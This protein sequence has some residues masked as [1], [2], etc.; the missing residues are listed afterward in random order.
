M[1]NFSTKT[2]RR[3]EISAELLVLDLWMSVL[4]TKFR[5]V[6]YG[7]NNNNNDSWANTLGAD[8]KSQINMAAALVDDGAAL[9][10]QVIEENPPEDVG[11]REEWAAHVGWHR[12]EDVALRGGQKDHLRPQKQRQR[13][14]HGKQDNRGLNLT[15]LPETIAKGKNQL[16]KT[17]HGVQGNPS[18][19]E[20][21]PLFVLTLSAF[22][23]FGFVA[24]KTLGS[25]A[26]ITSRRKHR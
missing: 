10:Q 22:A 19:S 18:I 14:Q 26:T 8:G 12:R 13:Q 9:V 20:G 6:C 23:C 15:T 4:C 25:R 2:I 3:R 11:V 16:N 7:K 21:E 1:G 5:Y 24:R 17:I